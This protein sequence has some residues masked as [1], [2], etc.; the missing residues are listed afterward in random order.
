VLEFTG[1]DSARRHERELARRRSPVAR[2]H[3]RGKTG[4]GL[5]GFEATVKN[6]RFAPGIRDKIDTPCFT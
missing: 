5:A 3:P 2:V 4:R 6:V 1:I